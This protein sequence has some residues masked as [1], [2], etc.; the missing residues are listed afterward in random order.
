MEECAASIFKEALPLKCQ[1]T[2]ITQYNITPQKTVILIVTAM[3]TSEPFD[4]S[5]VTL[6]E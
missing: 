3:R 5:V 2:S 1:Y 4:V 6:A